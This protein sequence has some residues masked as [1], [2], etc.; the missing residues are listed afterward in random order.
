MLAFVISRTGP[1]IK[2]KYILNLRLSKINFVDF[3]N[4]WLTFAI[5][6]TFFAVSDVTLSV[7]FIIEVEKDT[8]KDCVCDFLTMLLVDKTV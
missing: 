1:I 3:F 4:A 6:N 7:T 2:Y 5:L 8:I